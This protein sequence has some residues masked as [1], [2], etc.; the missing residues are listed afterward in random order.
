MRPR[1][2]PVALALSLAL[3]LTLSLAACDDDA[4][5]GRVHLML[6][7]TPYPVELI[8]SARVTVAQVAVHIEGD[9]DPWR[10]LPHAE[11]TYDL[12]D[13]QNGVTADLLDAEV[14]VGSLS[15]IRLVVT[16]GEIELTDGR[17]FAL[18]VPSGSSSGLKFKVR[19][20]I[21]IEGNLT[22]EVLLDMDVS[23][24][25]L[26]IPAA[27]RQVDD[28]DSFRFH[29]VVRVANLSTTGSVAG[30]VVSSAG[31]AT[32]ADDSALYGAAVLVH[33]GAD[34]ATALTDSAGYYKVMGLAPGSWEVQAEAMDFVPAS[35]L[36]DIVAGNVV[37]AD[38]LRLDPAP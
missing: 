17:S 34:S 3:A 6:G 14:P 15:E 23:R 29:P 24:S 33:S 21:S 19:P 11:Q 31:T 32:T 2:L 4:E 16:S 18:F 12:L 13:L 28:I 8:E 25:F 38:S 36:V 30:H 5:T 1:T 7:D 35:V 10:V 26:P 20:P 22:S 9:D 37:E 27:P